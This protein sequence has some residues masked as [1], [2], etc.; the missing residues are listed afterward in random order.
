LFPD[1][2]AEPLRVRREDRTSIEQNDAGRRG[3]LRKAA[4]KEKF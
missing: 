1:N 2:L 4:A 3:G